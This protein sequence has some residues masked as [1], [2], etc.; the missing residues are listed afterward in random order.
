MVRRRASPSPSPNEFDELFP[1]VKEEGAAAEGDD[2]VTGDVDVADEPQEDLDDDE[3][4]PEAATMA[5]RV[6]RPR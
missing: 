6:L 1:N 4:L 3:V 5:G 2:E